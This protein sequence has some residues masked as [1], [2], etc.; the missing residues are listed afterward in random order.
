MFKL[1]RLPKLDA[2]GRALAEYDVC[3]CRECRLKVIQLME[4]YDKAKG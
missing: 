1:W 4:T 2:I 3:G